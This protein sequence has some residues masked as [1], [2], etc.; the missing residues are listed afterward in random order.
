[1]DQLWL[2]LNAHALISRLNEFTETILL[3]SDVCDNEVL[4]PVCRIFK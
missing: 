2:P 3:V 4:L 1:M